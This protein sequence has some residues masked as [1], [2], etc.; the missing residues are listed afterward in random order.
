M[1]T[2]AAVALVWFWIPLSI[3]VIGISSI[4]SGIGFALAVV[5][6]IYLM[7]GV[8]WVEQMRSEAVSAWSSIWDAKCRRRAFRLRSGCASALSRR[9]VELFCHTRIAG[10]PEKESVSGR[11]IP[12][13]PG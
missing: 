5:V 8:E 6:F 4:P 12:Q 9:V 1:I 13:R 10:G 7:R 3:V 11:A 2:G